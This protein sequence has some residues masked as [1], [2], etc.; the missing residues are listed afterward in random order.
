LKR[1]HQ[2]ILDVR[3]SAHLIGWLN[4]MKSL[5][6]VLRSKG[7][8]ARSNSEADTSSSAPPLALRERKIIGVA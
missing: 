7:N 5:S 8:A 6:D 1:C 3:T 4:P 2:R